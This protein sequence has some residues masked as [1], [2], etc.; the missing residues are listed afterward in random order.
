MN[1][2]PSYGKP[3][4]VRSGRMEKLPTQ[5]MEIIS[6]FEVIL[7]GC[8]L[9]RHPVLFEKECFKSACQQL[10]DYVNQY[11]E[12]YILSYLSV[13]VSGESFSNV[14]TITFPRFV[15]RL[16]LPAVA[17]KCSIPQPCNNATLN[18]FSELFSQSV[19]MRF[20][21]LSLPLQTTHSCDLHHKGT[22]NIILPFASPQKH[23]HRHAR[24]RS[25][26]G[27]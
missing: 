26:S 8:L 25:I 14:P 15:Q 20:S 11:I 21:T 22:I 16:T 12:A 2:R 6:W 10:T 9:F 18:S 23:R 3:V 27:W 5:R 7:Y 4:L 1:E 19:I 24:A 17:I 13:R